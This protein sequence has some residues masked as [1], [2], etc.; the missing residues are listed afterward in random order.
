MIATVAEQFAGPWPDARAVT[1]AEL[2]SFLD[3]VADASLDALPTRCPP[4]TVRDVT[5]HVTETFR[6]F[7]RTLDQGRSGDFAPPFP[8]AQ[9]DAENLR[10]VEAFTGDPAHEFRIAVTT[11]VEAIGDLDEPIPHQGGTFPAA[12]VLLFGLADIVI[13]HD[14]VLA[15]DGRHYVPP[16]DTIDALQPLTQRLFGMPAGLPDLWA[17]ILAGT[18]RGPAGR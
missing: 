4:W 5:I 17:A 13:H 10:A 9:M 14:D 3:D 6:R 2:A 11:F 18:G 7:A 12:L 1:L 8:P 15:A 16:A